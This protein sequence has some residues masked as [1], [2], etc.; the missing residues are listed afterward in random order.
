MTR[1][2]GLLWNYFDA[3]DG[4][5]YPDYTIPPYESTVLLEVSLI[6][7]LEVGLIPRLLCGGAEKSL[8]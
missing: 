3:D 1:K 4:S 6:P 7:R 8:T 2:G 5:T